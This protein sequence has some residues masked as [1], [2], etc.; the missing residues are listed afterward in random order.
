[1]TLSI[2]FRWLFQVKKLSLER[3]NYCGN[4]VLLTKKKSSNF[5]HF[6][7]QLVSST[8]Q[9][10]KYLIPRAEICIVIWCE[11]ETHWVQRLTFCTINRF[12]KGLTISAKFKE[13][14]PPFCWLPRKRLTIVWLEG[15]YNFRS[16]LQ[17]FSSKHFPFISYNKTIVATFL[18][19]QRKTLT[20]LTSLKPS[21]ND[22]GELVTLGFASGNKLTLVT[23]FGLK[24]SQ[25][26]LTFCSVQFTSKARDNRIL[27]S[28]AA[29]NFEWCC[30]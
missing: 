8:F 2:W 3:K 16:I 15:L 27:C 29:G 26:R 14:C 28:G 25:L 9:V 13:L 18:G 17:A 6:V 11:E 7:F 1:M 12:W 24:W 23:W 5:G 30:D 19:K 4:F 20:L 10:E 22:R 21:W